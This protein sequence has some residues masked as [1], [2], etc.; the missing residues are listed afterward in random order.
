MQC[1]KRL[2][3]KDIVQCRETKDLIGMVMKVAGGSDSDS[4]YIIEDIFEDLL[5]DLFEDSDSDEHAESIPDDS[6]W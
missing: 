4:E 3:K 5:V 6:A 1:D 2:Y